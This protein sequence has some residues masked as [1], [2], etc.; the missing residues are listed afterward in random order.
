VEQLR[1]TFNYYHVHLYLWDE[2]QQNLVMA[3]GTGDAGRIMLSRG[4]QIAKGRGLVGRAADSNLSVLVPDVLKDSKWLPNPLLPDTKAE[5]AVPIAVGD[6]VL[7]VLDVQHNLIGGLKHEDAELIQSIANQV[8][9]ALQNVRAYEQTQEQAGRGALLNTISQ[10]I[11]STTDVESAL[12]I[13][14]REV[15]R[16][17]GGTR[18]RVKLGVSAIGSETA[19]ASVERRARVLGQTGLLSQASGANGRNDS[20]EE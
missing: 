3:G 7:G 8:A 4:H 14:A 19:S 12:R 18:A 9:I 16:A 20:S 10:R 1:A 2:S 17:L 11:Q 5:V 13:A 6:R 15:G